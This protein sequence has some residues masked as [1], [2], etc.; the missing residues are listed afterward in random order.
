MAFSLDPTLIQMRVIWLIAKK[1]SFP[2]SSG[3][4]WKLEHMDPDLMQGV[5]ID[6]VR[7][8]DSISRR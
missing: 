5:S 1:P 6:N 7:I 4:I 2:L 8:R 3:C